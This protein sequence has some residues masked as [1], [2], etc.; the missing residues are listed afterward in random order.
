MLR[1]LLDLSLNCAMICVGC[2]GNAFTGKLRILRQKER[3]VYLLPAPSKVSI[4]PA[5][6]H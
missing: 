4:Q 3:S 5:S 6:L 1:S 2:I